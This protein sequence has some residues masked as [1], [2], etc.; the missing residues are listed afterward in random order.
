MILARFLNGRDISLSSLKRE[1][2]R[3][4]LKYRGGEADIT[5]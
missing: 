4:E 5:S 3:R 2:S 1:V